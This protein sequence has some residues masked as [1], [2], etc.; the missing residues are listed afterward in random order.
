MHLVLGTVLACVAKA[1][2]SSNVPA[3]TAESARVTERLN[4]NFSVDTSIRSVLA[5]E[6]MNTVLST[7]GA[8]SELI[9]APEDLALFDASETSQ[10]AQS[11]ESVASV[12]S[13][14]SILSGFSLASV[15][16]SSEEYIAS[17]S[18]VSASLYSVSHPGKKNR[19]SS[20]MTL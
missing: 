12:M 1:V 17:I 18:S 13:V 4:S 7:Q 11:L 16:Q 6:S 9:T 2:A 20:C 10:A 3:A 15:S 14:N 19:G 5:I 8:L